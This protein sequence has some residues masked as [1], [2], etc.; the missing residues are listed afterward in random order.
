MGLDIY[1]LNNQSEHLGCIESLD[2]INIELKL[3]EEKTG[4]TIDE[5]ATTRLYLDHIK[6][7]NNILSDG[8]ELKQFLETAIKGEH[9]LKLEGD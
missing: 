2:S 6:F 4:V 3:L 5:Y 7:L 1:N 9:G 8:A